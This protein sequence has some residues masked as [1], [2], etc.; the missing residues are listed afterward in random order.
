MSNSQH[1]QGKPRLLCNR[2]KDV[3]IY[4]LP[5]ARQYSVKAVMQDGLHH[6]QINMVVNEPSL[7]IEEVSCEMHSVPDPVCLNAKNFFESMVGKR[8]APGITREL[9]HSAREGCR[10]LIN[11][12]HEACYNIT[13]AQA[14]YGKEA[15]GISFPGITE[16]QLYKIF[17]WFKEYYRPYV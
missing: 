4:L 12:F 13:L 2:K 9:N 11:L 7:K 14:T 6:M 3:D 15:L 10:H 16:E 5:G 17:L 1:P 8:I